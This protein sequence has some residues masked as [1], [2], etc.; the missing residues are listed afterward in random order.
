MDYTKIFHVVHVY[1]IGVERLIDI[2]V[3][4]FNMIDPFN[5]ELFLYKP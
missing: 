4:P 1:E 2:R 3:R 5:A